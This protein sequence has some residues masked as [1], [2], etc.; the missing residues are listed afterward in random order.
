MRING[1]CLLEFRAVNWFN[2][3]GWSFSIWKYDNLFCAAWSGEV[4]AGPV[5]DYDEDGDDV[6]FTTFEEALG[7]ILE[8]FKHELLSASEEEFEHWNGRGIA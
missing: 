2:E 8:A 6:M 7:F 1:E 3:F 5:C 4:V